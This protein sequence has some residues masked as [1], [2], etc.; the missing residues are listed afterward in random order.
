M[1]ERGIALEAV[2]VTKWFGSVRALDD[3]TLTVSPGARVALVGESGS[4]KTTLL[5]SFNRMVDADAGRITVAGADVKATDPVQLRRSLG[6]V[7]QEGGLLPHWTVLRNAAMVPR[8]RN[9][10]DPGGRG[11]RALELVGLAP[12][13]FAERWPRELSGGQRQRVALARALASDP[14]AILLDEPFG[15]LDAITR[16]EVQE[17]FVHTVVRLGITV[18]LVTHDLRE[19]WHI[20]DRVAVMRDGRIEQMGTPDQLRHEPATRYV[21]E[22]QE[23]AGVA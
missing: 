6:Y 11:R 7:Q 21:A 13:D 17:A 2:G 22:L 23:R 4:G 16:A 12:D 9:M 1:S 19:A 3:V 10:D 15:A 18:L 14:E 5:R 20:S 8:L